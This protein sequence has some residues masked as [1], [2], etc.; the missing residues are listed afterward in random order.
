[1]AEFEERVKAYS[2]LHREL[3]ATLPALPKEATPEQ[4]NAPPVALA[5]L[6]AQDPRQGRA[7]R[8]LHEGDARAVPPLPGARRSTGPQGRELQARRSWT[9][10]RAGSGSTS[11]AAIPSPSRSRRCRRRCCEALPKLPEDARVPLHRRPPDPARR[12][13]PHHRRLHRR[14]AFHTSRQLPIH[15]APRRSPLV[16]L[17]VALLVAAPAPPPRRRRVAGGRRRPPPQRAGR[18]PQ[19]RRLAQVRACSA[20]SA[21]ASASSTSSATQMAKVH[22]RFPFELVITVGDNLYGSQRPKDF[23]TKFEL[24]YKA[25]LDASVKFYASLGNHDDARGSAT[26]S[27][28]TWTASCTTRSRRRSRASASSRSTAPTPI[29][30][31]IAW[32]EKEL[33]ELGRGL[34]DP[35]TSITRS[36]P[37]ASGTARRRRCA[38]VL[39]AAVREVRRQRRVRRPRPLLRAHQAAEGHRALRD[40]IGWPAAEGE[41]RPAD[42]PDGQRLRHRPRVP[43]RRRSI[44]DELFFNAI[45][46]TGAVVDSG[47]IQR[48]KQRSVLGFSLS[49]SLSFSLRLAPLRRRG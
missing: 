26:T 47:V 24:P 44:G 4:I 20:I 6:I 49:F 13:R 8:H 36:T 34:E 30:T 14:C 3:E 5:A 9:R 15:H 7:G 23:Q 33:Q 19:S 40:R 43:G 10:T 25:L 21:P 22:E 41:H 28:S 38:T 48:R 1:M 39:G 11:T 37:R 29:R 32:L 16:G 18:A 12:P 2:T 17:L 45:S 42:R 27:C 35:R 31:Q 46:R